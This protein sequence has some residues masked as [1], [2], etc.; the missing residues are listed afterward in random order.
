MSQK[1][2]ISEVEP[3]V[4]EEQ[5]KKVNEEKKLFKTSEVFGDHEKCFAALSSEKG[6]NN[7]LHHF[8][9][10]STADPCTFYALHDHFTQV[11]DVNGNY[12]NSGFV[13]EK[14]DENT[15]KMIMKKVCDEVDK[16][17][18]LNHS[19]GD[20]SR[21]YSRYLD[22]DYNI[23]KDT[24]NP[25]AAKFHFRANVTCDKKGNPNLEK[26][27]DF[28]KRKVQ[29]IVKPSDVKTTMDF[30]ELI[31]AL[32]F[33]VKGLQNLSRN[34]VVWA[35]LDLHFEAN[36]KDLKTE[37]KEIADKNY[38]EQSGKDG[39]T[40]ENATYFIYDYSGWECYIRV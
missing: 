30:R 38:K 17:R 26:L 5:K 34:F 27:Y 14:P 2:E 13:E 1:R 11:R 6:L 20:V 15:L 31:I 7:I 8:P 35:L 25:E 3:E 32:D 23:R 21:I 19:H 18:S 39:N 28:T 22:F 40:K 16:H 37:I 4:K 36:G 29:E 24:P 12:F 33:S 9:S 10:N